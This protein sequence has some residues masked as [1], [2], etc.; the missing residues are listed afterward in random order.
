MKALTKPLKTR[1]LIAG[2]NFLIG[3]E[4]RSAGQS[5]QPQCGVAEQEC[6]TWQGILKHFESVNKGRYLKRMPQPIPSMFDYTNLP[7]NEQIIVIKRV[8]RPTPASKTVH[9]ESPIRH[10][11]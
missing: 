2:L 11:W 8:G 3:V 1:D 4:F 10:V 6:D 7:F 9:L 5:K